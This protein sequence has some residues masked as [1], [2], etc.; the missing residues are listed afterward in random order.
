MNKFW[1]RICF[2]PSPTIRLTMV[3]LSDGNLKKFRTVCPRRSDQFYTVSYY[4]KWITTLP[5]DTQYV[6]S[7]L[8]ENM[9]ILRTI[10]K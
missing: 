7:T 10:F 6:F 2:T 3:F 4:I 9:Q 1:L 5:M 8:P